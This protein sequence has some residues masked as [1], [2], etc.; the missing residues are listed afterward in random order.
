MGSTT[1]SLERGVEKKVASIK[2]MGFRQMALQREVQMSVGMA[3]A[4]DQLQY[5]GT[6][7]AVCIFLRSYSLSLSHCW[8]VIA[9]GYIGLSYIRWNCKSSHGKSIALLRKKVILYGYIPYIQ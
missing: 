4:R 8:K 3:M 9:N 7:W 5:A 6:I 2:D 1:S